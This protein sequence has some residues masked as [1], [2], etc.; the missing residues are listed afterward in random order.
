MLAFLIAGSEASGLRGVGPYESN[1][2][3]GINV[4]MAG[5][6]YLNIAGKDLSFDG[7]AIHNTVS[8]TTSDL[9]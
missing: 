1:D 6:G 5:G 9:G 7:S 4:S 8:F 2:F 3:G